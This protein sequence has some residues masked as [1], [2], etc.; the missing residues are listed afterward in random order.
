VPQFSINSFFINRGYIPGNAIHT[1]KMPTDEEKKN[2]MI[3]NTQKLY[4]LLQ[5]FLE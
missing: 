5:T 1:M 3:Q 2:K 4:A